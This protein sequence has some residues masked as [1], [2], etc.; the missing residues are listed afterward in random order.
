MTPTWGKGRSK[1]T[2]PTAPAAPATPEPPKI[3]PA[4]RPFGL[5]PLR[6]VLVIPTR[7]SRCGRA[8]HYALHGVTWGE[9]RRAA[10][11]A[12]CGA[13]GTLG[14]RGAGVS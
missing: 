6:D 10:A 8:R 5:V 9:F 11:C 4:P 12:E 7:C 1:M 3:G 14:M 13:V 2:R